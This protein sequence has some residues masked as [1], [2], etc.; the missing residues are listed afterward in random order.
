MP[1][2]FPVFL[3]PVTPENLAIWAVRSNVIFHILFEDKSAFASETTS[4][5]PES[6]VLVMSFLLLL[7]QIAG[8]LPLVFMAS[9]ALLRFSQGADRPR[10]IADAFLSFTMVSYAATEIIGLFHGIAVLPF[11]LLWVAIDGW[12]VY[13]LWRVRAKAVEFWHIPFG[14][15][16]S[17]L[18]VIFVVS[19]LIACT[20]APNNW[21][22]LTYHLPRIE[23]W[24]Q[25]RSL[26]YYPTPDERQNQYGPLAEILLLQLRI[27]SG[28]DFL[29]PL[30]QWISMLCCVCA[31][32]R[33]TRQLGGSKPQ[34]W[35]ASIF[36]ASLPIGILE[37]TS[38]QND[39]VVAALLACFITLGLD[40]ISRPKASL[41][42]ILAA[43]AAAALSGIV[44]PTGYV[45][46]VGFAIWF[47]VELSRGIDFRAFISRAAG[48]MLVLIAIMGPPAS[49][50][51]SADR[52]TTTRPVVNGSFGI[53]QTADNLIRNGML[54]FNVGIPGIDGVSNR[55]LEVA[56]SYLGLDAHRRQT[57]FGNFVTSA[58]P[59]G[60]YVFHEDFGP[61][62]VHSL[63]LILALLATAI[64]WRTTLLTQRMPYCIAWL[65]G[66]LVL[67]AAL[68]WTPWNTRFQLPLFML[69]API[70]ATA[71][72]ERFLA[73]RTVAALYLFL[74]L[75]AFPPLFF[76]QSRQLLPLVPGRP[77]PVVW[78]RPSYLSQTA[79]SRLFANNPGLRRPF[80]NAVNAIRGAQV[81][82]IGLIRTGSEAWEYPL[83]KML[84]DE[85][86]GYPVRI[87]HLRAQ[88]KVGFPLGPFLPEAVLRIGDRTELDS[89]MVGNRKFVRAGMSDGVAVLFPADTDWARFW[90][91]G[92]PEVLDRVA[93]QSEGVHDDGWM[94]QDGYVVVRASKSGQLV[95]KGM[96]P[97]GIGIDRQQLEIGKEPGQ[98]IQRQLTP[99][100]FEV[101]IPI[102]T[103]QT[104]LIFKFSNSGIL[105][106][107]DGRS[108]GARLL[109]SQFQP[110]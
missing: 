97:N 73:T 95:L 100:P 84:R 67:A 27:L 33:I 64:R 68:R 47:A 24:I 10:A 61:N 43:A 60:L 21:D 63:L 71:L 53:K 23:H 28:T 8:S 36:V 62:P 12:L 59:V 90:S 77:F 75:V 109:S 70:V 89:T 94:A 40:A 22:S 57:S 15:P 14:L 41:A 52:E 96:V 5:Q 54:N 30:I 91:Q 110:K 11:L 106:R 39:Y 69:G 99:G 42:L 38:T 19:L 82:Q 81:T 50:Y 9:V 83:W 26:D 107:G 87:E 7:K 48:V 18:A 20:A 4:E 72:P 56:T 17:I 55:A 51:L 93:W 49:R 79:R 25:N 92:A 65:A 76:N 74:A 37:S 58:P 105:P 108:V 13:R 45:G 102:E 31:V 2:N 98:L 80:E 16:A 86:L 103:D 32:Y 88:E 29:Y 85:G 6:T 3:A 44:K 34:C 1:G 46:G 35:L 101:V 66:I 104:K 78:E